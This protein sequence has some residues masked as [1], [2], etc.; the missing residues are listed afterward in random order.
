LVL[1]VSTPND[2]D[3]HLPIFCRS[4]GETGSV[5]QGV[6]GRIDVPLLEIVPDIAMAQ[7]KKVAF[8]KIEMGPVI[9]QGNLLL[10]PSIHPASS[11]W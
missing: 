8:S 3:D 7:Y 5:V 4:K 1:L 2:D 6:I 11:L 9:G 10:A